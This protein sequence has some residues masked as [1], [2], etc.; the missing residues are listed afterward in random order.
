MIYIYNFLGDE[1]CFDLDYI[2]SEIFP[3][4]RSELEVFKDDRNCQ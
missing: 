1:H 4:C 2:E 3:K